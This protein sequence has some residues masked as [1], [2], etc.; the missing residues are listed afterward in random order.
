M[1]LLTKF[2]R[3]TFGHRLGGGAFVLLPEFVT[4]I[5]VRLCL[6]TSQTLITLKGEK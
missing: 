3:V 5:Y 4:G 6:F 2:L 1:Q